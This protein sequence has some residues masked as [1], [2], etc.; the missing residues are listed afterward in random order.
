MRILKKHPVLALIN[1]YV[2]DS[3]L[4]TNISY[5]YNFGSIIGIVLVTQI[6]TGILLAMHYTAHIDLAFISVEH[7]M[8]DVNS[9]WLL[10]YAHANGASL[11]FIGLYLHMA[12]GIYYGSYTKPRVLLWSVGV[13]IFLLVMATA[14]LGYVLPW[15][16]MSFWG[17]TV[18]TNMLSAIPWIGTDLVQFIW[19]GY[20]VDNATLNRFYSLHYLLP[21]VIVAV[22]VVH[23]MALHENGG[24]N[25]LG[26]ASEVDKITFHPYYTLKDI[27][28]FVLFFM[29]YA[30]FIFFDPN[31]L[32][33]PDNYIPANP[34]VTP[35]HIVP[36]WYYL[37]FYAILRAIPDKLGGVVAMFGSIIILFALPVL[38]T[39]KVR[40]S[41]FRPIYKKAFWLFAGDVILLGW[42]GNKPVEE[43]YV[44][45]GQLATLFY[46]SYFLIIIPVIGILENSLMRMAIRMN[47]K[48][49]NKLEEEVKTLV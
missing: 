29:L 3:P 13:V 32:G 40:T 9:G 4:P 41:A 5:L 18:I 14:F 16:S 25:P 26:V 35:T 27:Y 19:G 42:L 21:F 46:F 7:I 11:F 24:S 44:G 20:S 30:Y 49:F 6:I 10:R 48:G 12:R 22:T 15:G 36:E 23:L 28:G 38:H 17:A 2:V 47:M 39:C 1:S 37:P 43:P 34:L 8:R 45:I 31:V 33:H